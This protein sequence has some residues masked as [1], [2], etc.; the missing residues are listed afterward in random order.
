MAHN[1]RNVKILSI[2]EMLLNEIST[3]EN[4]E[5]VKYLDCNRA[6]LGE[7]RGCSSSK[8]LVVLPDGANRLFLSRHKFQA[9]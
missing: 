6:D 9:W 8:V 5:N 1:I 2:S 7:A 4:K 3:N